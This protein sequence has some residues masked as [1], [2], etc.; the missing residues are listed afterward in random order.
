MNCENSFS[1]GGTPALY[2]LNVPVFHYEGHYSEL[3][4]QLDLRVVLASSLVFETGL[5]EQALRD[6]L[7]SWQITVRVNPLSMD[8]FQF[9]PVPKIGKLVPC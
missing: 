1:D 9:S 6:R 2:S 7:P 3:K 5:I 8:F 4:R